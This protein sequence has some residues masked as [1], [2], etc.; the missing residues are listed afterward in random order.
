MDDSD[1]RRT[2][3]LACF[4][5][6]LAYFLTGVAAVSMPP[7]LQGR[8]DVSPHEFWTTLSAHPIA[9]LCFHWAWVAVGLFGIAAA[10]VLTLRVWPAHRGAALWSG[11]AAWLGFAVLAR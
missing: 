2:G 4:G 1:L 7:A 6:A 5:V 3:A 8:P 11:L 10:P 9:H